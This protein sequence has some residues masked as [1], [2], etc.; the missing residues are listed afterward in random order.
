M[1]LIIILL[2][3]VIIYVDFL[4][5][6]IFALNL[7]KKNSMKNNINNTFREAF[8]KFESTPEKV[9]SYCTGALL[10]KD[11]GIIKENIQEKLVNL[12]I[13]A[14]SATHVRL[15][16]LTIKATRFQVPFLLPLAI[17]TARWKELNI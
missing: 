14:K 6:I 15:D 10:W 7:I 11:D 9:F 17:K 12:C 3:I 16:S 5:R 4:I 13:E 8:K 1:S 2:Y